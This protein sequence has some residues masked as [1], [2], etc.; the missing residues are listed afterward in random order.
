MER[1]GRTDV[2]LLALEVVWLE[3]SKS[4]TQSMIAGGTVVMVWKE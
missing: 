2:K 1:G 3:A 4:T